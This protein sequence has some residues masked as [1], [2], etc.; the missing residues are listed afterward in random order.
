MK[1]HR[2]MPVFFSASFEEKKDAQM[3]TLLL[4]TP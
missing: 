1:K 3:G 2:L 4:S